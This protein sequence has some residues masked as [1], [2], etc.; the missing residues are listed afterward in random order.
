MRRLILAMF[1]FCLSGLVA[2][3]FEWS[4]DSKGNLQSVG[5]PGVP[6]WQSSAPPPPVSPAQMGFTPDEAAKMSG[7]VLVTPTATGS[8]GCT[9]TNPRGMGPSPGWLAAWW[10]AAPWPDCRC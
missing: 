5:L 3:C 10:P 9:G 7:P 4:E 1:V 6:V 8:S 2:G